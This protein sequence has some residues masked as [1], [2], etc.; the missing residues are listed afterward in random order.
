[1]EKPSYSNIIYKNLLYKKMIDV[2]TF[3]GKLIDKYIKRNN[4]SNVDKKLMFSKFISEISSSQSIL[5]V[6]NIIDNLE[7]EEGGDNYQ[8]ENN[9]DCSDI[10]AD[11]LLGNYKDLLPLLEEQLVDIV[12]LGKCNSGRVT[13]LLQVW[14][15]LYF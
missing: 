13:R 7:K 6:Q 5:I 15:C 1:M 10:L 9:I 3:D 11:I 14:N 2:H 4:V 8:P 12:E